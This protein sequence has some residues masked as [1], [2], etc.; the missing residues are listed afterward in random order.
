MR[1]DLNQLPILRRPPDVVL[2]IFVQRLARGHPVLGRFSAKG[3]SK[4]I[5]EGPPRSAGGQAGGFRNDG[6]ARRA[7]EK[8]DMGHQLHVRPRFL[9]GHGN[10]GKFP[11]LVFPGSDLR[12]A[13]AQNPCPHHACA[14]ID[15][16]HAPAET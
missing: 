3:A 5:A 8:S 16:P 13:G 2:Q 15:L 6:S 11:A 1:L 12:G 9:V 4:K 10:A 14:R 7:G